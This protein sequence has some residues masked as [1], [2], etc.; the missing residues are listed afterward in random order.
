MRREAFDAGKKVRLGNHSYEVTAIDVR[1]TRIT[2]RKIEKS[3]FSGATAATLK[4]GGPAIGF[5]ADMMDGN[6]VSFPEEYKGKIVLL[7]FWASWCPPCR[8]EMPNVV[9]TYK[10]Y[11]K[12]GFEI[13]G[14]SLD[15][16]KQKGTVI[17]FMDE[18]KMTWSQIYDGKY[19]DAEIGKLYGVRSIPRALL[20]DGSTGKVLAIGDSLRG[21]GLATLVEVA[22]A[23]R[24]K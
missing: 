19:W 10:K 13:L 24:K 23:K 18:Y 2:L 5:E 4:V 3:I 8:E 11:H 17:D 7:D 14:V 21:K 20:I 9:A 1:G 12:E 6:T 22:L 16:A 15:E